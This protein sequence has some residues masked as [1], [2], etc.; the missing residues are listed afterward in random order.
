MR[1]GHHFHCRGCGGDVW[2]AVHW[3]PIDM[4]LPCQT[5]GPEIVKMLDRRCD[6]VA[7]K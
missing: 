3:G 1:F 6:Q 5:F 2:S 7:P 4:C